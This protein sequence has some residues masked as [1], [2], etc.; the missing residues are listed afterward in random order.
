MFMG[1]KIAIPDHI[2]KRILAG[3]GAGPLE[4]VET[5]GQGKVYP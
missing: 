5:R 2:F 1:I 4:T 3:A